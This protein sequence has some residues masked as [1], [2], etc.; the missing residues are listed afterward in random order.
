MLWHRTPPYPRYLP[1]YP[2]YLPYPSRRLCD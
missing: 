2:P 1:Q